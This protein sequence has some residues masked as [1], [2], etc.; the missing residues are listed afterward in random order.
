MKKTA[1]LLLASASYGLAGT[2]AATP[3]VPAPLPPPGYAQIT[4]LDGKLTVDIQE[5]MRAE[6][7]E[8]N[9]DFNSSVNGPQDAS[10]LLQRFRLGLGYAVT[11]WFKLYRAID[12]LEMALIGLAVYSPNAYFQR[13]Q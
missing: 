2:P 11:P 5:K 10:W 12:V 4:F 9:F 3:A 13:S 7:R 8:N 1:L 6:I